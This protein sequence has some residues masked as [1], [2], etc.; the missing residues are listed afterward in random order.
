M[1]QQNET[2]L[3]HAPGLALAGRKA[4]APALA[5]VFLGV[6]L[7][8]GAGFAG[9]GALHEAAHDSRHAFGF[10]CH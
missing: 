8:A 1:T 2:T 10:P 4:L 5:A 9:P 7:I 6:A 3:Q